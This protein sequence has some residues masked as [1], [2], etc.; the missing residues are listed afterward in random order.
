MSGERPVL[1]LDMDGVLSFVRA[2]VVQQD[3]PALE[4][5]WI[6]DVSVRQLDAICRKS[7]AWVVVSSVWRLNRS[8]TSFVDLLKRHG[9]TGHLHKDWRTKQLDGCIRGDEVKEWLSRHPEVTTHVI[10][11]DDSDFHPDQPLVL[12]ST[13]DGLLWDHVQAALAILCPEG[14]GTYRMGRTNRRHPLAPSPAVAA[15]GWGGGIA[16]ACVAT[17]KKE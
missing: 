12:T 5:R 14:R 1:F 2:Y 15:A 17:D 7:N 10:L 16:S 3:R 13:H 6:C 9:F 11:D 8:R 4:D